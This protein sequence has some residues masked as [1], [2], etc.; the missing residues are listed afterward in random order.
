MPVYCNVEFITKA[1]LA[2]QYVGQKDTISFGIPISEGTRFKN[3]NSQS[4]FVNMSAEKIAM[5]FAC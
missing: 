5:C 1:L 2:T 3:D 4:H